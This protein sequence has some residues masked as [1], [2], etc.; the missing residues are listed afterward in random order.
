METF[1]IIT[2]G[3]IY[4][5]CSGAFAA[6][7]AGRRELNKELWFLGGFFFPIISHICLAT[8]IINDSIVYN[9]SVKAKIICSKCQGRVLLSLFEQI[10]GTYVCPHCKSNIATR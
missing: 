10:N 8:I 5:I 4:L 9:D 7:L 2:L 3:I 6:T 1:T